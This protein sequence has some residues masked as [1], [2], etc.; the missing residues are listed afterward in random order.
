MR[1][2]R[3]MLAAVALIAV[4]SG[5]V[6]A[7]QP[8]IGAR[9]ITVEDLPGEPSI[10][11]TIWYPAMERGV[12][13]D[14]EPAATATAPLPGRHR[15]IVL[16]HGSGGMPLNHRSLIF[17]LV[18]TGSIVAAPLHPYDNG[19]DHSGPGTDLQ[20]L[21]RPR[22][23]ARSIDALLAHATFGPLIDAQR[24]GLVGYSAGGY[25]GLVVV[26]GR[27]DFAL[28]PAHCA[29]ASRDSGF[30]G[31]MRRGG[32]RRLRPDW[33]IVHD[34]RVRAAVLLAPAYGIYFDRRGLAEITAPLRIYRAEADEIVLH[35]YNE[36]QLRRALPRFPEYVVVPGGHFV[37][38]SPCRGWT[39]SVWCR[40][41][42]G[43]DRAAVHRRMNGEIFD[44]FNRSLGKD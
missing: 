2:R 27:P 16:S 24:I 3:L 25:T 17:H 4:L 38:V 15:L 10:P 33:T 29:Q 11:L 20:L 37:F 36:D 28:G 40:D 31:W 43:V 32:I 41:P 26:G 35:P 6:A 9:T 30:C 12:R 39:S 44:F 34:P 5:S 42:P 7:A 21:G 14:G 13:A 22:H 1:L 8:A 19:A 23:I 18:E